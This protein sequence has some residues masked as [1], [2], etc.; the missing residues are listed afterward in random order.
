MIFQI[1]TSTGFLI[2]DPGEQKESGQKKR[3]ASDRKPVNSG[4]EKEYGKREEEPGEAGEKATDQEEKKHKGPK[5]AAGAGL[6]GGLDAE[7]RSDARSSADSAVDSKAR[8]KKESTYAWSNS[9]LERIV[10]NF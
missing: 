8:V 1:R 2:F 7:T 3:K 9:E 5:K 4:N 10:S 6:N